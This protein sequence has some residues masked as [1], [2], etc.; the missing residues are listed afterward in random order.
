M[1][2]RKK[3]KLMVFTQNQWLLNTK[4][5]AQ[6]WS[7]VDTLNLK[8]KGKKKKTSFR[9]GFEIIMLFDM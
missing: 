1:N 4:I 5:L 6:H 3:L 2:K 8:L 7:I 9:K